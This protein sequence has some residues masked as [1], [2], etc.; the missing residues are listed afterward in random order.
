MKRIKSMKVYPFLLAVYPIL[1]LWNINVN[2][3]DF[4]SVFRSL[5]VTLLATSLLWLLFGLLFRDGRKAGL[6]ATIGVLL[7]FSYGHIFLFL[8]SQFEGL[9]H[10]SYLLA[11]FGGVFLLAAWLVAKRVRNLEGFERF[12]T[13]TGSILIV[14]LV[15]Q[16]GWYQYLVYRASVEASQ[17]VGPVI[18]KRDQTAGGSLPDVYL[19]ILDAH[20]RSDILKEYYGYDNSDFIDALTEMGFIV[21][22]C[23]QSNYPST[24]FSLTSMMNANYLQDFAGDSQVLPP[25][26]SSVVKQTLDNFGYTT[27]AFENRSRGHFDLFE[28]VLLSG[29]PVILE[30][31][32]LFSGINE[33][34][35]ML[36]ET[37]LLRLL[38][39]IRGLNPD[40]VV[41]DVKNAEYYAHYL[42]TLFILD[43]L[44]RLP[45][46][47]GPI[48][49]FA[50]IMVPH[51][52]FVFTSTG[53][54]E[55]TQFENGLTGYRENTEFID[56]RL[57]DVLRAII[58]KSKVPPIIIIMGDHGPMG[59]TVTIE[60][61]MSILN[62]FFVNEEAKASIY[63]GITPVNSFRV[64]FNHHFGGDYSLLE[65][66][67]FDAHSRE[68]L[69]E[70]DIIMNTCVE[71]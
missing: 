66:A 12:L 40:F 11:V 57:P 65:D 7:F 45:E 41:A 5:V 56:N 53:E 17:N 50:H 30:S 33:F 37:S 15:L 47:E 67:S 49:V 55:Y 52:P 24:K 54:Y 32:W 51:S 70:P 44:E 46:M 16:L 1:A 63:D 64:I 9:T 36:I 38:I 26:R 29:R 62:A 69:L 25:L 28:D 42:Q 48:F 14:Y 68:D 43:E 23:S 10:H 3:V 27:V 58:E 59:E 34:E 18:E 4:G 19:I 6:L 39:D 71:K 8:K 22:E 35:S 13:V 61:R 21:A 20:T 31:V 60:Q 2:Y